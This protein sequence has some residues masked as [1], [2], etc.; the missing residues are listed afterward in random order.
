VIVLVGKFRISSWTPICN[1]AVTMAPEVVRQGIRHGIERGRLP[2][3]RTIALW[4]GAGL[5]QTC[6]GCGLS[7]G[8][9][10]RMRLICAD[11][12]KAVRFHHDCFE[13]WEAERSLGQDAP[14][15]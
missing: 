15:S 6:D 3:E 1:A 11:D 14:R 8:I 4:D 10:E 9:N 12:W 7:I 5:G 13:A 2:R